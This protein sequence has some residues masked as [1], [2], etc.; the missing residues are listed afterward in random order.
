[1]RRRLSGLWMV[2]ISRPPCDEDSNSASNQLEVGICSRHGILHPEL[3]TVLQ[4]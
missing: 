4:F 1:M 3:L 2:I